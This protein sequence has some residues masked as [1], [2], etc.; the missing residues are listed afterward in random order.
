MREIKPEYV[1]N[2]SWGEAWLD[3]DYLAEIKGLE[4]KLAIE[5]EDIDRPRRLGKGKKMT[6]FEGTGTLKLHKVTSRFIKL[7]SDNLKQGKQTSFTIIT[8]LADPDAL[9]AERIMLKNVTLEELT[10]ANWEA[11]TNGEEEVPFS[12]DDWEPLDLIE[13]D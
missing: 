4:A 8:K 5:Y 9:G 10:L 7:L 13:G 2:G 6:G 11:K 3:G 12:F 1:I